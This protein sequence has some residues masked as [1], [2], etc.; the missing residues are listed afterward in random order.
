MDNR[1]VSKGIK[2]QLTF[3]YHSTAVD[4]ISAVILL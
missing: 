3:I 1:S 2:Y 4:L